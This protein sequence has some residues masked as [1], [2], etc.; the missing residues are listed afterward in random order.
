[1]IYDVNSIKDMFKAR[2]YSLQTLI[3]LFGFFSIVL[4]FMIIIII[5]NINIRDNLVLINIL[6]SLGYSAVEISYIFLLLTVPI[7]I[8]FALFSILIAPILTGVVATIISNF[9]SINVPIIFKWWYFAL[10][11]LTVLLIYF[12][13]YVIT[14]SLNVK[15]KKLTSLTR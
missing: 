12:I 2:Q 15:H 9:L 1:M 14:W 10:T 8:I 6:Q 3:I 5:S 13:S 7:L 4:S 11:I